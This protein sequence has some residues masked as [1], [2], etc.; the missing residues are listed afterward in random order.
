MKI[1]IVCAYHNR[2]KLLINTIKTI[3]KSEH[4]DFELIVVDDCSD[5]Q[6]R[7]EDLESQYEFLKVIR[8]E[9]KD[10]WYINPC[11]PFNIGF[12]NATGDVVIIQNPECLH[13]GDVLKYVN[14][15]IN[16]K[17]YLSFTCY[18]VDS[19]ITD[20]LDN[21]DLTYENIKNNIDFKDRGAS[22]DGDD[23][24]YNHPKFRPVG[25]HFCCAI[26]KS[27]LDLLNGFD[28]RYANGI[29]YDDNEFL[30]RVLKLLN[31]EFVYNNSD[32]S[33][34]Y[35]FVIHQ[36][37]YHNNGDSIPNKNELIN[38]NRD[39]FFQNN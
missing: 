32:L 5:D 20:N 8:L 30:R 31:F 27:N 11:I 19:P 35:P 23:A 16:E 7:I 37:H 12:K 3:L 24:W 18:S 38:K 2:K 25:Y 34:L 15:N 17:N 9:K 28:E 10:K 29:G 26:M 39:L 6:N 33:S 22:I 4:K 14:E 13:V 36:Y 21:Y 1:S